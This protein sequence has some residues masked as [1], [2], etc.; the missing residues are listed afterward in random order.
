[1]A[2]GEF[3]KLRGLRRG[4]QGRRGELRVETDFQATK[5]QQ[6]LCFEPQVSGNQAPGKA[7]AFAKSAFFSVVWTAHPPKRVQFLLTSSPAASS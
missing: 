3:M 6:I 1:M 5:L 4:E 7:A 2:W